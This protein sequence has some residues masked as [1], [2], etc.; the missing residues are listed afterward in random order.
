MRTDCASASIDSTG[1]LKIWRET[2]TFLRCFFD[3]TTIGAQT[4]GYDI[5]RQAPETHVETT[6]NVAV[7]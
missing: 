1:A 6:C 7:D 4:H 3:E 2:P 5:R